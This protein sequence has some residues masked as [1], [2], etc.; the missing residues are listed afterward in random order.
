M[1]RAITVGSFL[2]IITLTLAPISSEAFNP[3]AHIF[4]AENACPDCSHKIDFYYGSNAPD[5]AWYVAN[6]EDW[7]TAPYDTHEGE[8]YI[9][10]RGFAWGSTQMAFARGW[11]THRYADY[12]AHVAY[13]GNADGYVIEKAGELIVLLG[14][15]SDDIGN[16]EFAHYIIEA[17]IDL[18]LKYDD[19]TLPGKLFFANLFR[20]WKD[21]NLMMKVFVWNWRQRK[22]D[23]LTLATAELTFRQLVNR[24]ATALMLPEPWDEEA[25]AQLGTELAAE[26]FGLVIDPGFLESTILPAA[27]ALCGMD[28][29]DN[30]V[31]DYQDVIEEAID[32]VKER[33]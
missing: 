21:R 24:Y 12:F 4:I 29:D 25:L 32:E 9:D 2:I 14:W 19:P 13:S 18:L 27:I 10:L 5:I 31:P 8:E 6:S 11:L 7:P 16:H 22:T 28:N 3:L 15:D 20:S 33:F 1:K 23:W 17:T 30:N 26:M